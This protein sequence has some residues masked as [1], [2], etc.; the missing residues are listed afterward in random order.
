[1][2]GCGVENSEAASPAPTVL[3][4]TRSST[5]IPENRLPPFPH[6]ITNAGTVQKLYAAAQILPKA[7]VHNWMCTIYSTVVYHVRFLQGRTVLQQW[8]MDAIGCY[9]IEL[10]KGDLRQPNQAFVALFSKTLG[11]ARLY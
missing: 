7:G 11:V 4:V 9:A 5:T 1:M 6:T 2:A 3:E 8:D 10:H